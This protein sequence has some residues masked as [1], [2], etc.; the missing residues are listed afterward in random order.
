MG[1]CPDN[2]S[3]HGQFVQ[4]AGPLGSAAGLATLNGDSGE[5]TKAF[6]GGG[7]S[8]STPGQCEEL[9]LP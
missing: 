9:F 6:S 2:I 3:A 4:P 7:E 8:E 5:E 1:C